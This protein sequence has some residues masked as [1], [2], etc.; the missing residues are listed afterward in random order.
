MVGEAVGGGS[1]RSSGRGRSGETSRGQHLRCGI[2]SLET[3][4]VG[5]RVLAIVV[6]RVAAM[7]VAGG[8][9]VLLEETLSP[10]SFTMRSTQHRL[11]L[12]SLSNQRYT[13]VAIVKSTDQALREVPCNAPPTQSLQ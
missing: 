2:C 5:Y 7:G 13:P 12:P 9:Q 10:P 6:D 8:H 3:F 1:G 11:V 4:A